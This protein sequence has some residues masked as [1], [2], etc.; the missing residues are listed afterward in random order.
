MS[1]FTPY[2]AEEFARIIRPGGH[3]IAVTPGREHLYQLKETAYEKPYLNEEPGYQL[4][5]FRLVSQNNVRYRVHLDSGED[6]AN[7][8]RMMPYYHTTSRQGNER[9]MALKEADTTVDFLVQLFERKNDNEE[10]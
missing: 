5:D 1:I 4:P 10:D 2:S 9:L 3:L 6:I 8:W 7:L